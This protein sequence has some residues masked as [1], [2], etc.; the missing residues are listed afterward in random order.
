[1]HSDVHAMT[2]GRQVLPRAE[3]YMQGLP[4][5]Q[6]PAATQEAASNKMGETGQELQ[7]KGTG[8]TDRSCIARRVDVRVNFARR[9]RASND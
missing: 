4:L 1:M 8:C 2:R 9:Q 6:S 7:A 5:D 3:E